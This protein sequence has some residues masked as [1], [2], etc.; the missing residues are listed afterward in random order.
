[1][2]YS[3]SGISRLVLALPVLLVLVAS[4]GDA[5]SI[6]SDSGRSLSRA[7][8]SSCARKVLYSSALSSSSDSVSL[9]PLALDNSNNDNDN[10]DN[11]KKDV[12]F[13]R[14][15]DVEPSDEWELDCYSRPVV[16]GGKKLWEVL[17][18]D[19]AGSFRYIKTLPSNQV[20]SK[21]LRATVESMMEDYVDRHDLKAPSLIRFF[22]GAMFNMINIALSEIDV[23]RR[24]SRCTFALAQWLEERHRDVYPKMEG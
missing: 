12:E 6:T 11:D 4:T 1:M 17:I 8:D 15:P 14:N 20:N 23:S 18:T 10:N 13:S 16:L 19:S 3:L 7:Q 2:P 22:R 24:P 5:F 21:Q 9:D